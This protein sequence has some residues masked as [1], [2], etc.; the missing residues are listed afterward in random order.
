LGLG[1]TGAATADDVASEATDTAVFIT[2]LLLDTPDTLRAGD[3][4]SFDLVAAATDT[5][6]RELIAGTVAETPPG[7]RERVK[8]FWVMVGA[9]RVVGFSQPNA[10]RR[11][12]QPGRENVPERHVGGF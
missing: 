1:N 8:V 9:L 11:D 12:R 6:S 3:R 5:L 7:A 2:T 4:S 10:D